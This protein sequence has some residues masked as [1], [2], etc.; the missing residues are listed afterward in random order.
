MIF[1]L[2]KNINSIISN[3]VLPSHLE[4]DIYSQT[5]IVVKDFSMTSQEDYH[6]LCLEY[7]NAQKI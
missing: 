6:L 3:Y 4:C 2:K 1:S 7:I 5:I